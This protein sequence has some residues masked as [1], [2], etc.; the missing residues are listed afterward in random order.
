MRALFVTHP[1]VVIDPLVPVPQWPLSSR[2]RERM[3]LLAGKLV[4]AAISAVWS[5][6]ERKAMDGAEILA[7]RLAI[8]HH[9]LAALGENDRTATG[10]IPEPE[11]SQVAEAFFAHPTQSVRGWATAAA[12]QDRIVAAIQAVA[13]R[14]DTGLQ[15]VVSHGGV[16]RLLRARLEGVPIGAESR[17][18]N[19]RGGCC[20]LLSAPPFAALSPWTDIEDWPSA[21]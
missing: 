13:A 6:D 8:P 11:F 17:P 1:E 16:G 20:M 19:P 9:V 2:G 18:G 15:L 10:Y 5:S 12:E 4:G 21:D 3:E 14:A 7:A